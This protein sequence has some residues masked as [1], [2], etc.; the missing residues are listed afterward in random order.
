MD[1]VT[2]LF[3]RTLP[4]TLVFAGMLAV[5]AALDVG[6]S[7]AQASK[8]EVRIVAPPHRS[9][10]N[11]L[12]VQLIAEMTDVDNDADP[13]TVGF[14]IFSARNSSGADV[15]GG[16]A[17]GPVSTTTITN[18]FRAAI[19]MSGIP[20]GETTIEWAV[21]VR[22]AA[23]NIGQSDADIG[24]VAPDNHVFTVDTVAP[25][26]TG[27]V[28]GQWWRSTRIEDRPEAARSDS[29]RAV[30]DENLDPNSVNAGDFRVDGV[31]PVAVEWFSGSPDSVFFTVSSPLKPDARPTI[32]LVSLSG[33]ISDPAG[34]VTTAGSV[35]AADG[36]APT[37]AVTVVPTI[38]QSTVMIDV[39]T[40]EP[41]L[42]PRVVTVNGT[43]TGL[44]ATSQTATST[45][46]YTFSSP[47]D[48]S[49]NV[50]VSASDTSGN[51]RT[52]GAATH[53]TSGAILFEI[54]RALPSP[55]IAPA[56]GSI[57][58][59]D[60][61][62]IVVDW[63]KEGA[64]YGLDQNGG[65]TNDPG[66]IAVD[67]DTHGQV[68]VTQADLDGVDLLNRV[69]TADGQVF[70]LAVFGLSLGQH[71]FTVRGTD[72]AG[73]EPPATSVTFT[74]SPKPRFQIALRPGWNLV[75]LP[76][77]PLDP[78]VN[79]VFG[80]PTSTDQ[81]VTAEGSIASILCDPRNPS[82][83]GAD[84][85]TA[86]RST[87]G[88]FE[89]TLTR[90]EAGR[91]YWVRSSSSEPVTVELG[92]HAGGR[93]QLPPTLPLGGGF[94]LV[95]LFSLDPTPGDL[96]A[97]QYFA[98]LPWTIAYEYDAALD[99]FNSL[100]PG[101]GA[102]LKVGQGYYLHLEKPGT[103]LPHATPSSQA[104]Q[105]VV[106]ST[107]SA[108]TDTDATGVASNFPTAQFEVIPTFSQAG[109]VI[110][111]MSQS[112]FLVL[113][114][115]QQVTL[116]QLTLRNPSGFNEDILAQAR[117]DDDRVFVIWTRDRELGEYSLEA[118][119][120]T[121]GGPS[122]SFFWRFQVIDRARFQIS[123]A[124]GWNLVSLPGSPF[125]TSIND[126]VPL[127]HPI[128]TIIT[129]DPT[130]AGGW[131][132]AVRGANGLFA[133]TLTSIRAGRAYWMRTSSFEPLKVDLG[134]TQAGTVTL[135]PTLREVAG[136]NFVGVVTMNLQAASGGS[137]SADEYFA[138][139]DW[140]RAYEYDNATDRFYSL[141]AG[142]GAHVVTGRGY[143]VFL[144]QQGDLLPVAPPS[145]GV[146]AEATVSGSQ[147]S[148]PLS[149]GWN[150]ISLPGAPIDPQINSVIPPSHPIDA[151]FTFEPTEP[152]SWLIAERDETGLFV[153][154]LS[155][156]GPGRAFWVRT[157][158]FEPLTLSVRSP[159]PASPS[160][161]PTM[162]VVEGWNLVGMFGIDPSFAGS[163]S[164]DE[165]FSGLR[166]T[167][168][169]EYDPASGRFFAL[170]PDNGAI[171]KSGRGYMVMLAQPG[172]LL[173]A[174]A[175]SPGASRGAT[176]TASQAQ[177]PIRPGWNLV[178]LPGA[179]MDP[180]INAVLLASV[181]IDIVWTY[182]PT[183]P[184]GLLTAVRAD[185]GVFEGV[186][187][188]VQDGYAYWMRS[189]T[190]TELT[191]SLDTSV[192]ST[193]Y[194]IAKGWNAVGITV[195]D[196]AK[197]HDLDGDG[198][199]AEFVIG[200]YLSSVDWL[201]AFTYDTASG[202]WEGMLRGSPTSTIAAKAGKG[203]WVY[204]NSSGAL[205]PFGEPLQEEEPSG[206][207]I[208]PANTAVVFD[209][210]SLSDA[211]TYKMIDVSPPSAGTELVG[212]LVSDDS[213]IKLNT[214]PMLVDAKGSVN[215][216]F[217]S[218]NPRY[219]GEN[220]IHGYDKVVITEETAG[221]D[222]DAPVGPVVFSHVIPS[223]G[224]VHIRHLLSDWPPGAGGGI[225]T[226]LKNQL[227][228]ALLHANLSIHST[229]LDGIK[230]HAHH[231]INII[232]GQDGPNF[233]ASFGNPGDGLGVL[234][235]ATDRKHAGFAAGVAPGEQY[236]VDGAALVHI[237]G[238]NAHD[239]TVQAR[240]LA[241]SV[242]AQTTATSSRLLLTSVWGLLDAALNGLD[243][244]A[245]GVIDSIAGEGGAVQAYVEAQRMA[246]YSLLPSGQLP[247]PGQS[248][249]DLA[250]TKAASRDPVAAGDD[251]TYTIVV[252]NNG[253]DT[254][255]G[256]TITDILPAGVTFVSSTAG[257]GEAA[258]TIT[259]GLGDLAAQVSTTIGLTVSVSST[260]A[261]TITNT[262]SVVGNEPDPITSNN[263]AS[264][265]TLVVEPSGA[266]ADLVVT[267]VST[268]LVATL[269]EQV[270]YEI[271]ITNKGPQ[272]ATNIVVYDDLPFQMRQ[273]SLLQGCDVIDDRTCRITSLGPASSITVTM[274]VEVR[275][276]A[277]PGTFVE[278]IVTATSTESDP[279]PSDNS[280]RT[281]TEILL[282]AQIADLALTKADS[283]DPVKPGDDLS[284]A[285]VVTNNGPDAAV[286][287]TLADTL[288][289]G[290]T[291]ISSTVGCAETLGTLTCNLG[292]L[293]SQASTTL[294]ILVSVKTSA[295]GA[296]NNTAT[297]SADT[298]DLDAKNNS[299][300]EDTTVLPPHSSDWSVLLGPSPSLRDVAFVNTAT[301]WAVGDL[302]TILKTT[303]G[304]VNWTA[305][306]SGS[307]ATLLAVD[308]IDLSTG[309]A[310]G[311]GGIILKTVDGGTNWVLQTSGVTG[312]LYD[313]D[314]TDSSNGW[315]T[316]LFIG[317]IILMTSDGGSTWTAHGTGQLPI[318][319]GMHFVDAN[320]GWVTGIQGAIER[321]TDGGLTWSAQQSGTSSTLLALDFVDANR[322]WAVGSEGTVL[323]TIDGGTTWQGQK[324]GTGSLLWAVDFLDANIGWAVGFEGTIIRT[325]DGGVTWAPQVSGT[326]SPVYGVHFVATGTGWAV[327]ADE[328]VLHTQDGGITWQVQHD[329][330]SSAGLLDLDF[331]D[332]LE[333]WAV[334]SFGTIL[335]TADGGRSFSRQDSGTSQTLSGA[336]FL[337][338]NTGWAVGSGG[339][340]LHTE[341]SGGT[342]TLQASSSDDVLYDVDFVNTTTGWSVGVRR[343]TSSQGII[344]KTDDAGVTWTS[345]STNTIPWLRAV[346][347][348]DSSTGWAAGRDGAIL[349]TQDGGVTWTQ[350][351]SN[352]RAFLL[353]IDFIDSKTGWAVGTSGTILKTV[354]GGVTWSVQSTSTAVTLYDVEFLDPSRGWVVGGLFYEEYGVRKSTDIVLSTDDGG[355]TWEASTNGL[356]VTL[357]A[358]DAVDDSTV[359]ASGSFGTVLAFRTADLSI[360]KRAGPDP[361][362]VGQNL[363]YTLTVS[364]V[365]PSTATA[366]V[367]KD[368]LPPGV[369]S[370][371]STPGAES[372]AEA[373]G[374][375]TCALPDMPANT[376]TTVT[377]LVTADTA[378]VITN[379][380]TVTAG[381]TDPDVTNNTATLMTTVDVAA[382]LSITKSD[383]PDPAVAG[384]S[385][386]YTVMVTNNGPSD[387]TAVT[388]TDTLPAGVAFVSSTPDS[389]TCTESS[390]TVSC[391]LG[392]L[393]A[394]ETTTVAI[395]VTVSSATIGTITN[396][397]SVTGNE[398]DP[399]DTNNSASVDTTVILLDV[400]V[401][402]VPGFNLLGIPVRLA[403]TTT[404]KDVAQ[405]MNDQGGQVSS[406][407]AW[408]AAA[409]TFVSWVGVNPDTNNLEVELGQGYFV[410]VVA[411]PS[412]GAWR[413]TG[414]PITRS[415]PLDFALGF[416]LIS[417]PFAEQPYDNAGL[418]QA[419][420]DAGGNISS[421]LAWN[422]ASQTFATWVSVNPGATL[423]NILPTAGYFV[424]VTKTPLS[425]F[426]P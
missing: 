424:R 106:N 287:V 114:F 76:S 121:V 52:R 228:V 275:D 425:P 187:T 365:G 383:S 386:S 209:D 55:V 179:P 283:Q 363:R 251:L 250:L 125:D 286:G 289:V 421:M 102:T 399:D 384:A 117:T 303:D 96:P 218:T 67:L 350:Q 45:F 39:S 196:S 385:L 126:V 38:S 324:S 258:G 240:D 277:S 338:R 28:T 292:D 331:V 81:I 325:T 322:G 380:A 314:F 101:T 396:T 243:A 105:G 367:L 40:N 390:G 416:N 72:E 212:W 139:L 91:A 94:N 210:V 317:G 215:H 85:L 104:A 207:P 186:L 158:T 108:G 145:A 178:S 173:P 375:I 291:Y 201:G 42:S 200:E 377:I 420:A 132:V 278:N 301:G 256:V 296:I 254:A 41:L 400:D 199:A 413:A 357:L 123:L 298:A 422:A 35:V 221:A 379:T 146:S 328:R 189:T 147:V 188:A 225:L 161:P 262:A 305:Q 361:V 100:S 323:K 203:Y 208:Q 310:V 37:I 339:T 24:T 276:S 103:L 409:Q 394:G 77:P 223:G 180:Q 149:P 300:T 320:V 120:Q 18:G 79:A 7:L 74:V 272:A 164:A 144:N 204:A 216:V 224:M 82:T 206:P 194:K 253:P 356:P 241:L 131:L 47:V 29:I 205:I 140:V 260:L 249:A 22:D 279:N 395:E 245:N 111:T 236:I 130:V 237:D 116:T 30:F 148:V 343:T 244:N 285:F 306:N 80:S 34:N 177:V 162:P 346:D 152:G 257:C 239:R 62:F 198:Q 282:P 308:F 311:S 25:V 332:P 97:D 269:G 58:N 411:P 195:T 389:P 238:K 304:G 170:S 274:L 184:G 137:V 21:G 335:K 341:S 246:T 86:V 119:A 183:V 157:T 417:V 387:A 234:L 163:L 159:D 266:V 261:G 175:P 235:H 290:V 51:V 53:T 27:A 309:W 336:S 319:Y 330:F 10:T 197:L 271:T 398:T 44:T 414:I 32:E 333:G 122:Q 136:F 65:P 349:R 211:I 358:I 63:S 352:T 247:S 14:A 19:T 9:A 56:Q 370:V 231:V 412:G 334:G 31:A 181:P 295:F 36:I 143:L 176:V 138:G 401:P 362:V 69:T 78:D 151:V 142:T 167:R 89:G 408:N 169:F 342:W 73:N 191:I 172:A 404:F 83:V 355:E 419:V 95:G 88:L 1:R 2:R 294:A 214:G 15:S 248:S 20:A 353:D 340:I 141:A 50:Q 113:T 344:L 48:G 4:V 17:L 423:F 391:T 307:T 43:T 397:A 281:L 64:E 171:V 326:F 299:A 5:W 71:T 150:L 156:L 284:Y 378:G 407:L 129:Y 98:S 359:L 280:A 110:K 222:P 242:L 61:F 70:V 166:W 165:Y 273:L 415:V 6:T 364:N 312:T 418:A 270:T 26:M 185:D 329:S 426:E 382:D 313:V 374:V 219:T 267:K 75:S 381:E 230:L 160:L 107:A 84:C 405:Q 259:C 174:P 92:Q 90:I 33:G 302:G 59:E 46:S 337:D 406:I 368:T 388:L 217:D 124:P 190:S 57:V 118:T 115:D 99:A 316:G 134:G 347:F 8:P 66:K 345:Q 268:P 112:P 54:D 315:V 87:G 154:T 393:N 233:D 135:P 402:V 403:T 49:F 128:D 220:L 360:A 369:T 229:T 376:S 318:Y 255:T 202:M 227:S 264:Q 3:V 23:G 192:T 127:A 327:G 263:T 193:S 288:P 293:P 155:K 60:S 133:G 168:A 354:D 12:T 68:I 366:V 11:S 252:T 371:S 213:S 109:G 392:A 232:E 297:V 13:T 182:D 372:C 16:I 410:R 93:T 321:T 265:D 373:S 351:D 348:V 153:G 226:N